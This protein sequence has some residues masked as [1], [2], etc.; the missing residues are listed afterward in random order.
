MEIKDMTTEYLIQRSAEIWEGCKQWR[1]LYGSHGSALL[2]TN[3]YKYQ[4]ELRK[5]EL[6]E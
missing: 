3:Y 2:F 6:C 1:S 5:R 4:D